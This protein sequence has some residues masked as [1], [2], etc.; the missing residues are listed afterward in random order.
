MNNIKEASIF[1]KP[2][3]A[4]RIPHSWYFAIVMD[5]NKPDNV[6]ITILAEVMHLHATDGS[7]EF[8]LGYKYFQDNFNYSRYQIRNALVRLEKIGLVKR[9]YRT[10]LI[11]NRKFNNEMFLVL[12]QIKLNE[13]QIRMK[14]EQQT[15]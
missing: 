6:A 1:T 4:S 7:Y 9:I 5:N 2:Y 3:T 13:L 10:V 11:H 12:N 8:H 15:K 14:N